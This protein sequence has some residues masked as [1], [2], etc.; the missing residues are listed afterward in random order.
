MRAILTAFVLCFA[1][2]TTYARDL[3]PENVRFTGPLLIPAVIPVA[4]GHVIMKPYLIYAETKG[5]YDS[6]GQRH[7][8]HPASRQWQTLLPVNIGVIDRL[9]ATAIVGAAY[10]SASG[11]HSDGAGVTD[12]TLRL[13]YMLLKPNADRTTPAVSIAY[14]HRFPTGTYDRL[15][16]NPLNGIGNGAHRDRFALSTENY[17]WLSNGRPLRWRNLAAWSPQPS[18]V[19]LTGRSVHGTPQDFHGYVQLGTSASIV[20]AFEYSIDRQW[21]LVMEAAWDRVNR[22][23]VRGQQ[24]PTG[25]ECTPANRNNSTRWVYSLAPAAEYNFSRTMGLIVGAQVSVAGHRNSAFFNPQAA[26]SMIF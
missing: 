4:P 2:A 9:Q 14:D 22:S 12:T 21:V 8:A 3:S 26:L 1:A 25:A 19:S 24:C 11:R 10:N 18:R 13:Q 15:D 17:F 6:E 23:Q 7:G 16:A 5:S 20:S